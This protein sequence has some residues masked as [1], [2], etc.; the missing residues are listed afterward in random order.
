MD[1]FVDSSW[2]FLRYCDPD[3]D[4]APFDSEIVDYWSPVDQYI[5]GVEHAIL[6]L[7]YA[8]FFVKALADMGHLDFQE[9]FARLFTQGMILRD[10]DK[11]SKSKGNV[12]SPQAVIDRYGA[13]SARCYVLFLGPP[14]QDADWSEEGVGGVHR[15][16]SRLWTAAVEAPAA[17]EDSADG[18]SPL[19]RKAH[20][21]IDK[22]TRDMQDRFAFNT[23]I[24]AVMELVNEIY[25]ERGSAPAEHV[26]FAIATGGS[27]IFPFAPHLGSEVYELMTGARV[28][29]AP[30]PAADPALLARDEIQLVVQLNGKLVDRLPAPAEASREQ[31][32]EIARGSDKL[33][34]RL[35]GKQIVKAVVV[36]GKLV[37]F[38]VR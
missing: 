16:L 35:N 28:W 8:R 11:M 27:L 10:G 5:G 1:T 24:A 30:W 38:V 36:P 9:P 18:P 31:L 37:N 7:L 21:A 34:A 33:A 20:W 13:D 4:Q 23:A 32:E 17:G 29:E 22:V 15:F 3:N 19:L 6:H 25:R 2:Y 26:R 14:G 12:V